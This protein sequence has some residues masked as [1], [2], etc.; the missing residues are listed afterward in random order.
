MRFIHL[1]DLHL[2]KMLHSVSLLENGDQPAWVERFLKQTEELKPDAVL[3]AGDIYDRSA[4][5]GDAVQ[6]LSRLLSGL[7]EQ[8][9]PVLL[10]AG[11]H[12]SGQRLA[13]LDGLLARENVYIAGTLPEG[14]KLQSVTLEDEWGPV[15]FWLLPYVFPTLVSE[16]LGDESI[17]DYETAVRRVLEEQEVDF[18]QRNVLLAHQN[19]TC[20]GEEKERGGSESMVGGLGQVD[21]SAFDGFSYVALGHIHAAGS[22][23]RES[24][25]Y[26]G[27]PLCYH[28]NEIRQPEK[29]ALL[30]ELGALGTEPAIQTLHIPP[31][32]P[33]RELKGPW[34]ALRAGELA[35]ER[36][37]EYMRVVL[38]D[39]RITPE[40]GDFFRSLAQARDSRVLEL[41]SEYNP[42]SSGSDDAAADGPGEKS[43]EEL[44]AAF[45]AERCGGE[46]PS[47]EDLELL[48]YAGELLR[49]REH[50][51]AGEQQDVQALLRFLEEQEERA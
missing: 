9:I 7:E 43:E 39:C 45:Y 21:V 6:L 10:V 2:G 1:S 22:V 33:M 18:S 12:D 40:I 35:A 11:N 15:H 37:G 14:G 4:P 17:R 49:H 41:T 24:V 51:D 29:G 48:H 13:F 23:G 8:K 5:S 42:F 38:T 20:G 25:R 26:V 27:T 36:R 44:F 46:N 19:V 30:V 50:R 3:I 16:K 31:L 28:F 47:E 32:H 34:E